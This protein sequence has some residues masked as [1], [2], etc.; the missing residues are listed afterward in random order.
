MTIRAHF[1]GTVIVPDEPVDL[2]LHEPI[3]IEVR[4]RAEGPA[5][6]PQTAAVRQRMASLDDFVGRHSVRGANI[7]GE[8]LRREHLYDDRA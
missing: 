6:V 3:E 8:Q 1:D 4:S 5:A 2:P 7:P